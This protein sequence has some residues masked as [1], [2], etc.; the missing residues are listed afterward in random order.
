[1]VKAKARYFNSSFLFRRH[2]EETTATA[3]NTTTA[4]SPAAKSPTESLRSASSSIA[5]TIASPAVALRE[6]GHAGKSLW[7]FN[8]QWPLGLIRNENGGCLVVA[9]NE[10]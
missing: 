3:A 7:K 2:I 9:R 8:R 10:L 1:V 4:K 6:H 5:T